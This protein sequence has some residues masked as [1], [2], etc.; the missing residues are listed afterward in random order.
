MGILLD[1][2]RA[3]PRASTNFQGPMLEKVAEAA[4][5]RLS[6]PPDSPHWSTLKIGVDLMIGR[7]RDQ[8]IVIDLA[9]GGSY[10]LKPAHSLNEA[11]MSQVAVAANLGPPVLAVYGERRQAQILEEFWPIEQCLTRQINLPLRSE[12]EKEVWAD[13]MTDLFF[14]FVKL[15]EKEIINHRDFKPEHLYWLPTTSSFEF[16]LIDWA[17]ASHLPLT[18]F[19]QWSQ[20]TLDLFYRDLSRH[21]PFIWQ[22]FLS[23][24]KARSDS[25]RE[26]RSFHLVKRLTLA[27][28]QLILDLVPDLL[29]GESGREIAIRQLEVFER[30]YP[31]PF[32]LGPLDQFFARSQGRRGDSLAQAFLS[33]FQVEETKMRS[34]LNAQ[35]GDL[36]RV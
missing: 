4:G 29:P 15:K 27:Y 5:R 21:D 31:S 6:L 12:R 17:K 26:Q 36:G 2:L 19:I 11:E 28:A 9:E 10:V 30:S 33:W 13:G 3:H 25:A 32:A 23:G 7:A 20:E 35:R 8:L 1:R 34:W 22:R 14:R 24:L 18:D 16:R